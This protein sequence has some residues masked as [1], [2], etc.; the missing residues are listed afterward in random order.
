MQDTNERMPTEITWVEH[1]AVVAELR[2]DIKMHWRLHFVSLIVIAAIVA[3]FLIYLN[4]Y[5]FASYE[6]EQDGQGVNIIGDRNG[7]EYL[8]ADFENPN[9]N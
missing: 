4:Q 7:V 1:R 3:G 5:D 2:H 6:Y 8:G 9:A